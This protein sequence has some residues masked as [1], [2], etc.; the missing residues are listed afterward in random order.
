MAGVGVVEI[1][2]AAAEAEAEGRG[3][4]VGLLPQVLYLVFGA[5]RGLTA[6]FSDSGGLGARRSSRATPFL[7]SVIK[8][9]K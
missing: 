7:R 3:S 1:T 8:P 9:C 6:G 5:A 2:A 4:V